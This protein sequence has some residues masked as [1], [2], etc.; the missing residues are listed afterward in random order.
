V[1]TDSKVPQSG[2]HLP[3]GITPT[4]WVEDE[5]SLTREK[6]YICVSSGYSPSRADNTRTIKRG[7]RI[8]TIRATFAWRNGS[9]A[10][11]EDENSLMLQRYTYVCIG[12]HQAR[13]ITPEQSRGTGSRGLLQENVCQK[14][15]VVASHRMEGA[16]REP[17]IY[18]Q[19]TS[20]NST[21]RSDDD[22]ESHS[23]GQ[24]QKFGVH[25]GF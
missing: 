15:R 8:S 19:F 2:Q 7:S 14:N 3:G 12:T 23:N 20:M 25:H 5:N 24:G 11:I 17:G 10:K 4:L 9:D 18:T 13:Q 1:V 22:K 6:V 16:W 21:C